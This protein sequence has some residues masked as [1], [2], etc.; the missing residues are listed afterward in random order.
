MIFTTE[1]DGYRFSNSWL[2]LW[3]ARNWID[4]TL[5]DRQFIITAHQNRGYDVWHQL[6]ERKEKLFGRLVY[7][8]VCFGDL[9]K[10]VER[11]NRIYE[12]DTQPSLSASSSAVVRDQ[13]AKAREGGK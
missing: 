12:F 6:W 9:D 3:A 8:P 13:N 7:Y 10:C 2:C 1:L 11:A 5:H 4:R